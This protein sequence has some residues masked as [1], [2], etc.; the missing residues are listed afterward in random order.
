MIPDQTCYSDADK[1]KNQMKSSANSDEN[2]NVRE[3]AAGSRAGK[4][5]VKSLTDGNPLGLIVSFMLPL[6]LGNIFQQAYNMVDGMIVGQMLGADALAAVGSSSSVQF[7]ILGLCIGTCAGFAIPISQRFGANDGKGVR[8]Y[9]FHS[10]ILSAALAVIMTTVTAIL[11]MPI[12]RLMQTP[13]NI[14]DNA[15]SYLLIIFLGIPFTILYNMT[16]GMLRAVGNSRAPFI[17]LAIS[18]FLNIFLDMFCIAV[19]HWGCAGA[20]IATI[21]SQALSGL[22]CLIYILR[23]VPILHIFREDRSFDGGTAKVLIVM[24]LPMGLQ[25]SITAIGSMVMQSANNS[26]GSVYV[27]GFTAGTK[28]KQLFLCPFDAM[29]TAIATF[30]SQ[31]YGALRMDRVKKGL[32]QTVVMSVLYGAAAGTVLILFGRNLSMLFLSADNAEALDAS[33]RYLRCMGYF[34]WVLG[35]LNCFRNEVQ[36]L[37]YPGR[38]MLAGAIEMGARSF[39]ATTF[40][41]I[42]G[43]AAICWTDQSAWCSATVYLIIMGTY[44]IKKRTREVDLMKEKAAPSGAVAR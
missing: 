26:L 14:I 18:T 27:S 31:N 33:A 19:L 20:A 2:T 12:L 8:R 35:L 5:A 40:V 17:F 42:F 22:F 6:L 16:A 11:C 36:A 30:I 32:R 13:A 9:V 15:Y 10:I 23:K 28:L 34:Y 7:L 3:S 38:A 43:Y 24:G 41:P 37:G 29:A 1:D 44:A 21:A 25:Y 39:V 4:S